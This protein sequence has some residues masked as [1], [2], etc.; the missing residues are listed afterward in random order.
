MRHA[1]LL[2]LLLALT[3]QSVM[4]QSSATPAW[5]PP[6]SG[7]YPER[8][9]ITGVVQISGR[10]LRSRDDRVAAFVGGEVR[11]VAA[12]TLVGNRRLFFITVAGNVGDGLLSFRAYDALEDRVVNLIPE[13][14]FDP[15]R[16][17]GSVSWPVVWTPVAGGGPPVWSVNPAAYPATMSV[18]G[19]V[20][21]AG[22]PVVESGALVG[23]FL[24][25]ELR[26]SAGLQDAGPEVA[27]AFLTVYGATDDTGTLDLLVYLP[28]A[29]RT[30]QVEPSISFLASSSVGTVGAPT[31]LVLRLDAE[32]MI[33]RLQGADENDGPMRTVLRDLG[34]LPTTPPYTGAPWNYAG[35]ES[36]VTAPQDIVDWVLVE[37]RSGDPASPPMNVVSRAAGL[38]HSGGLI[39]TTDGETPLSFNSTPDGDYYVVVFHRNHVSVMSAV[40]AALSSG[41]LSLDF[42]TAMDRAYGGNPMAALTGGTAFGM[43]AGDAS[44]D[45]IVTAPDFNIF[46]TATAAGA[47]GYQMADFNLDGQVTAPDLNIFFQ[48]TTAGASSGVPRE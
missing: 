11:G 18:V 42:T 2:F 23:A 27:L 15:L 47:D 16:P 19:R 34:Y 37:L 22:E 6:P 8:M 46:L 30:F 9:A 48:S 13:F 43:W 4:A 39:T 44:S 20:F 32:G 36:F 24:R 10:E 25:G 14:D 33:V 5:E 40:P 7:A 28:S 3:A 21:R 35:T 1:P 17:S 45:G 29:D 26:G 41:A 38:L 31:P 12:S